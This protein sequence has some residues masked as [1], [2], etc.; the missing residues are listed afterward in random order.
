[1][2]DADSKPAAKEATPLPDEVGACQALIVEQARA[3]IE[4]GQ[5]IDELNAYIQRLLTQI[6]GRRS[7]RQV[8][9]R[10]Q[11]LDFGDDPAAHDALAEAAD[12]AEKIVQEYTVRRKLRK[13]AQP[14]GEKFPEHFPRYEVE[15][16]PPTEEQACPIH[17]PK[18][19]IGF[20]V[21]ET[22]EFE[23]PKLRVRVTKYPKYVCPKQP[24]CGVAQAERPVGLVEG[25]RYDTSVAAEVIANKYAYHLP[26]YR[27]QDMFAGTGWT[28]SRSTLLNLLVGV[29][30]VVQPLVDHLRR[31]LLGDGGLG[32]DDT[33]V[34]LIVPPV[35]PPLAADHPRAQR[36]RDVLGQAIEKQLPSVQARMWGY[37]GFE[38]P[39]NVFDFTVSWHRDGPAEILS[40]YDGLLMCDGYA[41]F[42]D[43]E[44]S[45]ERIVRAACWSHAR[46]KL[47]KV[48]HD[49]V[50][51]AT[52]LLAMIRELYDV[53][54]RARMLTTAERLALRQ[55]VARPILARLENYLA[56]PVITEALPKSELGKAVTYLRNNWELLQRYTTDGRFP[57]DNNDTEQLMKQIAIGRKNW[58][59]VGS[60]AGGE[61]AAQLMT[62][63]SS[64]I[65]N[66]LDVTA[67]VKDVLDKLLAGSTDYDAL[68][69]H[70]WKQS[71][72]EAVRAY[73]VEER[74]DAA[75]RKRVRRA[76]RRLAHR[77]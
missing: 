43:I 57:I 33:H 4:Q 41:G 63:V 30:F 61:R 1:M 29:A 13:R 34:T 27:E 18:T 37:R 31:L 44:L 12:E 3:I 47:L 49:A 21:T 23:R 62:I 11:Q 60:V 28:P 35:L 5:K 2:Q 42:D 50:G 72:P 48:P 6:Y 26:L 36:I 66:D 7:E 45:N 76:S 53:E 65:R 59:F 69:P 15:V 74:R 25:N 52:V 22:L 54:D 10:Q 68:C 38:L 20:D 19:V 64:A 70:V 40:G 58:L 39:V 71:H 17:G 9:P 16:P 73:R 14:N 46:R 24:E 51:P 77:K 55:R 56:N 75:D 67:Y 8:D 32:C